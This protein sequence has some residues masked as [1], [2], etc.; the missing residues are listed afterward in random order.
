MNL[1]FF[2]I[3]THAHLNFKEFDD[4]REE[5]IERFFG[6]G[7]EKIINVGCDM[8]S[9]RESCELALKNEN[10]FAAVGI[11]PHEADTINEHNLKELE[12][13][14]NYKWKDIP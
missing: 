1:Y 9:S 11:H 6:G 3:D 14:V 8:K 10:I 4:D 2:M 13:L 12:E 5:V 7:G